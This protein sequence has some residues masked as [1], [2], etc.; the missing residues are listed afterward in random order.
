MNRAVRDALGALL[1]PLIAIGLAFVIGAV[2]V[3]A[4]GNNPIAAYLALIDGAV[5]SPQAIG[6]TLLNATPLIMT[7]LAVALP[8]RAGLFNIGGEGQVFIGA[9]TAA[10]LAVSLGFMGLLAIPLVL[11]ACLMTGF[12][13]GAIPGFLKA[14]FGAHEVITTIMLNFIGINL[15]TYFAL[16]PFRTEGVVPGTEVID[17]A[18]RLPLVGLGL[19]RVHYGLFVGLLAAVVVYLILWRTKLGFRIRTVGASP[20][21]AK[22]A[23]MRIGTHTVLALAIGGSLAALAGAVEVLGVYGRMSIPFVSNLGFNGIGVALLGRNHPVGVVLGALLFGG[24]A[25][26]AQQMQFDTEVPL[27]LSDVLLAVILLL[28]TA[29]KLVEYIIGKRARSLAA[30]TRLDEGVS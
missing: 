24:L 25:S 29:T 3:L 2:L 13:W 4:S 17:A 11:L 20:G 22:Y 6:R 1:F 23:G 26:G 27:D 12:L 15:A 10:V 30:G 21:A 7:G 18:V 5:G 19:S 28:V 8:F 14:R 16:G 9:I